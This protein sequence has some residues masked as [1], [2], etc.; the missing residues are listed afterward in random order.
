MLREITFETRKGWAR[1]MER[2]K[3]NSDKFVKNEMVLE[4]GNRKR[5][6]LSGRGKCQSSVSVANERAK[7]HVQYRVNLA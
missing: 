5:E 1:K 7:R 6:S 3:A 2:E 4:E